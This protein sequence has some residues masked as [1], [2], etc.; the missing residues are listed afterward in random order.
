MGN[1]LS[2]GLL[3]LTMGIFAFTG[4]MATTMPLKKPSYLELISMSTASLILMFTS[5]DKLRD[6]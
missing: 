6:G 4:T 5:L 2:V 3:G 1:S